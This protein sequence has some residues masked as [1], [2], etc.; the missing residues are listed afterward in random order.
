MVRY[1]APC[2]PVQEAL[3][4]TEIYVY[5]ASNVVEISSIAGLYCQ[6]IDLQGARRLRSFTAG[7]HD[8]LL[9]NDE[10][11]HVLHILFQEEIRQGKSRPDR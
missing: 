9:K 1:R 6:F 11:F 7:V 5:L 2:C 4:D 8:N 10:W 3:S